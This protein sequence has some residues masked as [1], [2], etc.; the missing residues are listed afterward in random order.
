V[1]S[2]RDPIRIAIDTGGTF[3]DCVWIERGS[4]RMLKVFSTPYDPSQAIV[5]GVNRA[6]VPV[7]FVLLHGTTIGTNTLLQ[8]QGARVALITTAGFEDAIEIGRQSRPKLYDFFFERVPPLVSPELRFGIKE[9]TASDGNLTHHATGLQSLA[10]RVKKAKPEAIAICLLFSFANPENER[11]VAEAVRTLNLPI[12]VSHEILPEFR[13]YERTSAVLMNAYLQPVM[14]KYLEQLAERIQKH[15]TRR[16][17]SIFV[18]Q[19]NGG[20]ASFSFAAHQPVRTVLSGP[21]GGVVGAAAMARR[22]GYERIISFDMGGTSTDVA[23]ID[24]EVKPSSQSEIAGLPIGVPMLDIHTVGA[25]GGSI[26]RFDAG[27]ALRV[28]PESAGADP[29]PICYGKGTVPTVS[30]ANLL[31]GRLRPESFLGGSFA[32]DVER[33]RRLVAEWLARQANRMSAEAFANGVVRVVNSNMEKALR[34]VSIGRGYD[35]R[36]FALVAFGGAAALHACELAQAL[37]IPRVIVPPLPGALSAYGILVSDVVKDFSR[38]VLWRVAT[39]LP[40]QRLE[41]QFKAL[42]RIAKNEFRSE[43]WR[44][45][46]RFI[47]SVDMRFRGQGYELNLPFTANLKGEF[48]REHQRRYGYA[49]ENRELEIVTLR[50][51]A[52]LPSSMPKFAMPEP[53][54]RTGVQTRTA[55]VWF[56]KSAADTKLYERELLIPLR[57]YSGPAIVTEYSATTVVQPGIRFYIDKAGNL[58]VNTAPGLRSTDRT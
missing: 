5:E 4:I 58:A 44:G 56:G 17:N 37:S 25:G 49:Y 41:K 36:Q 31:L 35:P 48:R 43:Q 9:R 53:M 16:G 18:M 1:A 8:R 6:G 7:G 10:A 20:I 39:E 30:D 26:A 57:T 15:S 3:T 21:A 19:S 42:E 38:T 55:R 24:R 27:G 34:L 11:S 45:G 52:V 2:Q 23:L 51:R 40:R 29:G 22:S 32:L 54:K 46:P 47:R 33:T 13:E 50:V 12:S 28:G 14:Q